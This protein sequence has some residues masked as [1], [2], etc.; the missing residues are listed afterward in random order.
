[1]QIMQESKMAGPWNDP[2]FKGA[3]LGKGERRGRASKSSEP[4][5]IKPHLRCT[6]CGGRI[7][8]RIP[9]AEQCKCSIFERGKIPKT[10]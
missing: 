10:T 1:M 5:M 9:L 2:R 6:N 3:I 8:T 4:A 7:N